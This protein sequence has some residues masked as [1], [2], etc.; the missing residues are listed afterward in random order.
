VDVANG[1][2]VLALAFVRLDVDIPTFGIGRRG[3]LRLV[4]SRTHQRWTLE[5]S[6]DPAGLSWKQG[7]ALLALWTNG[8][9]RAHKGEKVLCELGEPDVERIVN[10][11]VEE[12]D[13]ID[14]LLHEIWDGS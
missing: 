1:A 5:I 14:G 12:A 3:Y 6:V 10:S 7:E 4:S 8:V 13:R 11:F 9:A 2:R